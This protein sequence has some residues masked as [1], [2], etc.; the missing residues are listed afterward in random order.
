MVAPVERIEV[1][2]GVPEQLMARL[3]P[4][5]LSKAAVRFTADPERLFEAHWLDYDDTHFAH[6]GHLSVGI[7]PAA[8]A[9]AEQQDLSAADMMTAF[10]L[11]S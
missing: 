4:A 9:V 8:L 2:I 5:T 7:Y 6:V 3:N 1:V 10:L 11:G